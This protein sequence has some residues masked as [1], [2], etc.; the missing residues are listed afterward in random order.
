ME[1]R[2]QHG[3]RHNSKLYLVG[4][5]AYVINKLGAN[6]TV[7]LRCRHHAHCKGTAKLSGEINLVEEIRPHTCES[8]DDHTAY[9]P[10]LERM[11]E[12][13]T[14]TQFSLK[15]I[16]NQVIATATPHVQANCLWRRCRPM[17]NAARHRVYDVN[18]LNAGQAQSILDVGTP[19][20]A[21]YQGSF[22]FDDQLG[23]WFASSVLLALCQSKLNVNFMKI[24]FVTQFR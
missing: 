2:I 1:Y 20:N 18:P 17:L 22:T 11:R 8:T 4:E 9:L 7:Y 6:G 21:F 15:D 13:A 3:H 24:L 23:V 14:S 12:L 16:Y 10:Y 5:N 19:F